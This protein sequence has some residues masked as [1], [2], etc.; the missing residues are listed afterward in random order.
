MSKVSSETQDKV[1]ILVFILFFFKLHIADIQWYR[2]NIPTPKG[3]YRGTER[4]QTK[5]SPKLS[6]TSIRACSFIAPRTSC[7]EMWT[8]K[9]WATPTPD[10]SSPHGLSLVVTSLIA[11]SIPQQIFHIPGI[12]NFQEPPLYLRL[13][14]HN[15]TYYPFR[16][17]VPGLPGILKYGWKPPWPTTPFCVP[18]KPVPCGWYQ[19]LPPAWA[20]AGRSSSK[21]TTTFECINWWALWNEF[22]GI[23]P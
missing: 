1:A 8:P 22:G 7:G 19:V 18:V 20:V 11:C 4:T 16:R 2:V 6:K 5:A 3:R 9:A 21:A 14:S 12:S 17:T 23:N 15:V 13:H 10:D